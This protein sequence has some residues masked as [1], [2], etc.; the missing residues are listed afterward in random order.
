[1]SQ[2]GAGD[3][4]KALQRVGAVDSHLVQ[5]W[6]DVRNDAAHGAGGRWE[7]TQRIAHDADGLVTLLRQLTSWWIG[8]RGW[9]QSL[10]PG[11]WRLRQ[12]PPIQL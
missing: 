3:L 10:E 6:K 9:Y 5:L 8:Y 11:G 1:M 4:L 12:Y 7:S 2:V